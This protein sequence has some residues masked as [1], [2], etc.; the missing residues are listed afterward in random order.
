[1][2]VTSEHR[3]GTVK[4]YS[5]V[6]IVLHWTIA[7]LVFVQLVFNEPIQKAFDDRLDGDASDAMGGAAVHVAIG[8]TILLL[9][10]ARV[11]IRLTRGA[12]PAHE[13]TPVVLQWL[14]YLVHALLY[15]FIFAMPIAGAIAWFG[16]VELSAELHETGRLILIPLI[17]L[18]VLGGLAEH[19]VLR[20]D[21]LMRML[22][23][24]RTLTKL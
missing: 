13:S 19:F 22:R 6:Q 3:R 5:L 18:H 15:F 4:G 20:N 14:G 21:T 17:G 2:T 7:L 8:V 16:G 1:V 24:E 9:A 12:P 10:I 11:V 23:P